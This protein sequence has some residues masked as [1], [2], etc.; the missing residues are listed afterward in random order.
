MP[1][2][3]KYIDDYR[4]LVRLKIVRPLIFVFFIIGWRESAGNFL[5][6]VR[7]V[8]HAEYSIQTRG[9]QEVNIECS[10]NLRY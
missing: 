9:K 3:Y 10:E 6:R 2:G 7:F 4:R 1:R 5:I 8:S